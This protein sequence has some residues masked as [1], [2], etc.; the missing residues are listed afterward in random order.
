MQEA[1]TLGPG[2]W[3]GE[4]GLLTGGRRTADVVAATPLRLLRL[5]GDVFRRHLYPLPDV[6]GELTRV[7][8]LRAAARLEAA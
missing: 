8:L 2:D 3:F 6:H 7:A 1:A 4:I 5:G